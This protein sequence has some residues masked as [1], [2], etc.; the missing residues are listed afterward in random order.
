[1]NPIKPKILDTGVYGIAKKNIL[2]GLIA[3]A[4]SK[5]RR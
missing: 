1:M 5:L 4:E 3:T 2:I